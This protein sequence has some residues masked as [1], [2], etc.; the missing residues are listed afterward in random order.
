MS[1]SA[2]QRL[3]VLQLRELRHHPRSGGWAS[4]KGRTQEMPLIQGL[5]DPEVGGR[6]REKDSAQDP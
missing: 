3:A 1:K 2:Q 6:G 5:S 4:R